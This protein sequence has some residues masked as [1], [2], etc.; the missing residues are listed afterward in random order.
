MQSR[1]IH[2][3]AADIKADWSR[4]NGP[5]A[6]YL[7]AMEK[8]DRMGDNYGQETAVEIVVRFLSDANRWRGETARRIKSELDAM[9][10]ANAA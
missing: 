9:L 5:A 3:I 6:E 10:K 1:P 8:L 4:I 7:A 2:R